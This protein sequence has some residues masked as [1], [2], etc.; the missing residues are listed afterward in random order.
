MRRLVLTTD[1]TLDGFVGRDGGDPQW[2]DG[3]YDDELIRYQ[4]RVLQK[5]GVHA[6]E[7]DW[8][9]AALARLKADGGEYDE[10]AP[11]LAQ[12]GPEFCQELT[13]RALVDEYRVNVH[14]VV[15]G[16]GHRLFAAPDRLYVISTRHFRTGSVA[17]H[18]GPGAG[19]SGPPTAVPL[20]ASAGAGPG[21]G[22]RRSPA[23][24]SRRGP[25]PRL[26]GRRPAAPAAHCPGGCPA[27]ASS[28]GVG[29]GV[30]VRVTGGGSIARRTAAGRAIRSTGACSPSD[31]A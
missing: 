3:Y 10:L 21:R 22:P 31:E 27:A 9:F 30:A 26:T 5:A 13:R 7:A 15:F 14:P 20:G 8:T 24:G 12:G 29:I 16:D 6:L 4:L 1:L 2:A 18:L 17:P 28:L 23:R 19:L 11:I 25:S